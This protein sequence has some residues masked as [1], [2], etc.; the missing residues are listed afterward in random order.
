MKNLIEIKVISS[1]KEV[2]TLVSDTQAFLR[3]RYQ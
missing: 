2:V 3:E 1:L